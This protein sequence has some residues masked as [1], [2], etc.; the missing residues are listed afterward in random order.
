VHFVTIFLKS[1]QNS[2]SIDTHEVHIVKNFFRPLY[3]ASQNVVTNDE[4]VTWPKKIVFAIF[5]TFGRYVTN[6][7]GT[8]VENV[9]KSPKSTHP[10][11]KI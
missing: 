5:A 6:L 3:S 4:E 11:G 1:T 7:R 10:T 2:A 8:L 9:K